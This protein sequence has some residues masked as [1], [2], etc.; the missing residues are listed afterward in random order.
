MYLF[1]NSR[2]KNK[3]EMVKRG[4]FVTQTKLGQHPKSLTVL[5]QERKVVLYAPSE[6][7]CPELEQLKTLH[8]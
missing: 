8:N 6:S 4:P 1:Q 3:G 2:G 7:L 5:K